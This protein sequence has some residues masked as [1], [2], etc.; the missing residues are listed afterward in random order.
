LDAYIA[1]DRYRHLQ[2]LESIVNDSADVIFLLDTE[3]R[4]RAWNRAAE[5]IFGWSADEMLGKPLE[6][7]VPPELLAAG[8]LDRIDYEIKTRGHFY[9]ETVR[10]AKDGRRITVEISVSL[11]RDPAGSPIG[12]SAILRDITERKRQEDAKLQTERLALIGAMAA[13]L[14]H[15]IRNPMSSVGLNLDLLKDEI[16]SLQETADA[17]PDSEKPEAR[18]AVLRAAAEASELI[19]SIGAEVRRLRNVTEDY[20]K[21]A[22][23][24]KIKLEPLSLNQLLERHLEFMQPTFQSHHVLLETDFDPRLPAVDADE[25]QLWQAV[26]NLIRNAMDAMPDGGH[27]LVSTRRDGAWTNL[28]IADSGIGMT[29]EAREKLFM[30]FFSTK[31][32]GTGLGMPLTLQIVTEH[33][34]TIQCES[35]SGKG[36][37]IVIIL[38]VAKEIPSGE[39][40]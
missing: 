6:I 32:G 23:L 20:L 33:G 34:G 7:I 12:R 18:A 2:Q 37:T 13:K 11:L 4:F 35:A 8:E 9:S 19:R 1:S 28:R 16:T 14:A 39:T 24:P 29:S 21:F 26:L 17:W 40:Q 30:P 25:E 10:M 22:R 38:P 15:E 5:R 27:L 36:T 31:H 3:N